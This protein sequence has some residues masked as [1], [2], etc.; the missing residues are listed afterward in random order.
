M[1]GNE[2]L[3]KSII[4]HL[5]NIFVLYSAGVFLV[6]GQTDLKQFLKIPA[7]Y[8][9]CAGVAVA[10]FQMP[11]LLKPMLHFAGKLTDILGYGA[12]P[13]LIVNL[14]YSM[15]D[16]KLETL[17]AGIAGGMV[18]LAGG[19]ILGFGLVFLWRLIG[20]TPV[21]P[22]LDPL[23]LLGFRTSE[24][25]IILNAS[26]PG[27]VMAYLLNLKYENCP[28]QAAAMVAVGTLGG[29]ISIPLVLH[30]IATV[31]MKAG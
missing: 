20:W 25:V 21:D 14:G 15:S 28:E 26:M 13:L 17:K 5:A 19:P 30:L 2:G 10:T 7:L 24:A 1:F 29:I 27:P 18:R 23:L 8:A 11:E 3:S 12:I 16:I 9:M 22:A 6:S 4:F 31:I